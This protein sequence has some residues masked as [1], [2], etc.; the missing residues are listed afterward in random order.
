MYLPCQVTIREVG[1]RDGFQSVTA[2][3]PTADKLKIIAA[4]ADAGVKWMETTSFVSRRAIPQLR[5]AADVMAGVLSP[6]A[7]PEG[8]IH[9][10]MVPNIK[11][12][13]HALTAGVDELVAIVSA[14]EAHNQANI[15]CSVDASMAEIEGI[16]S[17]A[18][19]HKIPVTGAIAV[20]FGCPFQ[21]DVPTSDVFN[22]VRAY[23]ENGAT[24]VIL[25]DTTGMATPIRV[26]DL[27]TDFMRRFSNVKPILHFHNNRGIAMANLL[28][29]LTV[30]ADTFDT[31]L[32]GIGGCP[33]V[34][35]AAGNLATEDVVFMLEDMGIET[36][37][38][39]SKIIDAAR[40]LE[41]KLGMTL[42]GQVMKS[43]PR[44]L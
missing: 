36:G 43:G 20:T 24:S 27:V 19:S 15:R 10:A 33:Y 5:D 1:P 31:A 7:S 29:A 17:L 23:A 42:P 9:A 30:G 8:M 37:I 40:V 28:A 38:N 14:S 25:A 4:V 13:E 39:L 16:C 21:G 41:K 44:H 35:K 12:A 6:G 3:I 11:G 18:H 32:G 26:T 34:P 2:F 22:I